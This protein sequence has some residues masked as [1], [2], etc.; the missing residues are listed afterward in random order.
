MA[1]LCNPLDSK[2]EINLHCSE[3]ITEGSSVLYKTVRGVY[4]IKHDGG[5]LSC[6]FPQKTSVRAIVR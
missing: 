2:E 5:D 1:K 3:T 6:R 4:T